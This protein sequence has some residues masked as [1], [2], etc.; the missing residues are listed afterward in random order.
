M[1]AKEIGKV[2]VTLVRSM[3]S[4]PEDQRV[5]LRALGLRKIR[6]SVIKDNTP[7]IAGMIFKVKHLVEVEEV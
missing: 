7:S 5:T 1:A 2:K 3:V 4:H 6:Q